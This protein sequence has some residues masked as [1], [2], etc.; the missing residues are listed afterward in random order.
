[1]ARFVLSNAGVMSWTHEG[2]VRMFGERPDLAAEL[3]A[4]RGHAVPGRWACSESNLTN[5][6]PA[7]LRADLVVTSDGPPPHSI[8]VEIQVGIDFDRRWSWPA[9]VMT[10]RHR[11]RGLRRCTVISCV[12]LPSSPRRIGRR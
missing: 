1:L 7:A 10:L 2:L 6:D 11:R 8:V 4:T 9:Y 3:V 12:R 5:V